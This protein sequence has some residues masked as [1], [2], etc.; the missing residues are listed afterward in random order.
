MD[1]T[2]CSLT[3]LAT[4]AIVHNPHL[5]H[6]KMHLTASKG[7]VILQGNVQSFFEKQMA[8]EALRRVQGIELIQNE[9]E[10]TTWN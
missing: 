10:V 7:K 2:I 5:N 8:Q 6:Q 4:E 1:A 9:L 3:T